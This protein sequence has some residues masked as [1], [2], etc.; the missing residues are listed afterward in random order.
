M[1]DRG[2]LDSVPYVLD[3]WRWWIGYLLPLE[4]VSR[5]VFPPRI[6]PCVL[7]RFVGSLWLMKYL[8][9]F[10]KNFGNMALNMYNDVS[11]CLLTQFVFHY[12]QLDFYCALH[13]QNN[14]T[15]L[16]Q[17]CR[18]QLWQFSLEFTVVKLI[19]NY[20]SVWK[21]LKFSSKFIFYKIN[22]LLLFSSTFSNNL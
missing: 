10:G 4:C 6:L 8:I 20:K 13:T 15:T 7:N 21:L 19:W 5:T 11:N 16:P 3:T 9:K 14:H 22:A 2:V 18:R 1:V 12:F 17:H